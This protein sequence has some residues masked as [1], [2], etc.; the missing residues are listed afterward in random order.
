M[1]KTQVGVVGVL[2]VLILAIGAYYAFAAETSAP[3]AKEKPSVAAAKGEA[4]E[5]VK[6]EAKETSED[7]MMENTHAKMKAA[8]MPEGHVMK[9]KMMS[10]AAWNG[11]EPH[12]LLGM[13]KEL[14]L[15]DEQ[16]KKLESIDESSRKEA[17]AV[18]TK[19]QQDTISKM[20]G[21]STMAGMH[22]EMMK[23]GVTPVGATMKEGSKAEEAKETP[24]Q[25]AKEKTAGKD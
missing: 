9:H 4:A 20:S 21:P 16:V 24:A 14:N 5:S 25:E 17:R 19:E 12:G 23:K 10:K 8:G 18:L 15:T 3:A 7:E 2:V 13:R 1:M 11:D 6:E 22:K